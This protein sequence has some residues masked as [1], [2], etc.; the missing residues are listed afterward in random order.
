MPI[1]EYECKVCHHEFETIQ[2]IS[3]PPLT[4]C[5]QCCEHELRKKV[6]VAAFR[7]KG[8]GWYE[9]DFKSGNKKNVHGDEG[10]SSSKPESDSGATSDST[11]NGTKSASENS[12]SAESGV[13]KA[14][15]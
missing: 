15:D 2:K 5:P 6:S 3:E 7:L 13:S 14:S 10:E 1:Y 8:K 4:E 12:T 11:P 9:T